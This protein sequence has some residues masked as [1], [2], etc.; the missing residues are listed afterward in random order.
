LREQ[1][2]NRELLHGVVPQ[3][4]HTFLEL[5]GQGKSEN[6]GIRLVVSNGVEK[7]HS[8]FIEKIGRSA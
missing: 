4:A 8:F 2:I 5:R 6:L 7:R 1:G 3:A